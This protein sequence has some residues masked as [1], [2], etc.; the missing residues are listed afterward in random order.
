MGV[1]IKSWCDF[2]VLS[3]VNP[4]FQIPVYMGLIVALILRPT[5]SSEGLNLHQGRG[6]AWYADSAR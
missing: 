2:H 6:V 5:D 1:V 3:L 4:P